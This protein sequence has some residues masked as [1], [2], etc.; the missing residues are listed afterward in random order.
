MLRR[1]T[2]ARPAA[3]L[4]TI[5]YGFVALKVHFRSLSAS[6]LALFAVVTGLIIPL[7][8]E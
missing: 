3:E 6:V 8:N 5:T 1:L 2:S 7:I 4:V